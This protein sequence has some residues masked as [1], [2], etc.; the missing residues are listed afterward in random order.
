MTNAG[1]DSHSLLICVLPTK[2]A[3]AEK[4][5]LTEDVIAE[6]SAP[7]GK[8]ELAFTSRYAFELLDVVVPRSIVGVYGEHRHRA[9]LDGLK[10]A[11]ALLQLCGES[12]VMRCGVNGEGRRHA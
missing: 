2:T 6:A 4:N 8:P 7:E 10:I 11:V 3:V 1:F 9:A 5:H 12:L